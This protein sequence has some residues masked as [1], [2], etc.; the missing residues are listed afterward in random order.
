MDNSGGM[1]DNLDL[2][3]YGASIGQAITRFF[4]RYFKF[5][6]RSSRSEY[7][8]WQF[9]SFIVAFVLGFVQSLFGGPTDHMNALGNTIEVLSYVFGLAVLI[10]TIALT[11]RRLHDT[12]KSG[13]FALFFLLPLLG[14]LV[15]M[16]MCIFNS[17]P[18]G[19][20]FDDASAAGVQGY[21]QNGSAY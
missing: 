4:K 13:L 14:G 8:W 15:L 5:A 3:L 18:L 17:N 16:I 19:R 7:W 12:N 1:P 21:G 9:F 6:G 2:P 10:P 11:V 20:R